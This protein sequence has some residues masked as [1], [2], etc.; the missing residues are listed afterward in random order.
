[1]V[2][3]DHNSP[4][5]KHDGGVNAF[6]VPQEFQNHL[7][8]ENFQ[9]VSDMMKEYKELSERLEKNPHYFLEKRK[10]IFGKRGLLHC[11]PQG[12]LEWRGVRG[13]FDNNPTTYFGKTNEHYLESIRQKIDFV[14]KIFDLLENA[15]DQKKKNKLYK[16]HYQLLGME[17]NVL[18]QYSN[19]QVASS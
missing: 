14:Y 5:T 1:M 18:E 12:T 9:L 8:P 13:L 17:K 10:I 15:F 19:W 2:G 7:V 11:H 4:K 6:F 3:V 16:T